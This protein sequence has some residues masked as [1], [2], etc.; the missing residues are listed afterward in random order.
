MNLVW[1]RKLR[2]DGVI[3]KVFKTKFRGKITKMYRILTE[4]N[5]EI[6][7]TEGTLKR[8][9]IFRETK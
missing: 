7:I 5:D 4:F 9:W 6:E 3:I 2:I 8:E 1:N